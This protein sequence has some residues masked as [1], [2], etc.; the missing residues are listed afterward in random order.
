[1]MVDA[2]SI[3]FQLYR[4]GQGTD[5][6]FQGVHFTITAPNIHSKPLFPFPLTIS[7]T[8]YSSERRMNTVSMPFIIPQKKD[9]CRARDPTS[10]LLFKCPVRY[11]LSYTDSAPRRSHDDP[12]WLKL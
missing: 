7:E 2:V 8:I 11:R 5:P 10:D 9:F 4:G 3:L 1:M 6:C 12:T